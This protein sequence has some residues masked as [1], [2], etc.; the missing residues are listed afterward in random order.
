M[1]IAVGDA[2]C[3]APPAQKPR[4]AGGPGLAFETWDSVGA[5]FAFH[6]GDIRDA[7]PLADSLYA[8]LKMSFRSRSLKSVQR[9]AGSEAFAMRFS[10]AWCA[11]RVA[12]EY[13]FGLSGV[14]SGRNLPLCLGACNDFRNPDI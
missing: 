12:L 8:P 4:V 7:G 5:W 9:P 2:Y 13:D 10:N 11:R 6:Y 3:Y 14:V 1:R